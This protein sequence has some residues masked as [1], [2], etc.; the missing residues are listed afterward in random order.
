MASSGPSVGALLVDER[1]HCPLGDPLGDA[2]S[3]PVRKTHAA[4]RLGLGDLSRKGR[5]MYAVA[6]RRKVDPDVANRVIWSRLDRERLF[7]D[8]SA[9][10]VGKPCARIEVI[11]ALISDRR[12]IR[13]TSIPNNS[14]TRSTAVILRIVREIRRRGL[15]TVLGEIS[16]IRV[17]QILQ[18]TV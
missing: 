10:S 16:F 18:E 13:Q 4:M 15:A 5:A 12:W 7:G 1:D 9:Q 14:S 17:R 6:L 8:N 2:F 3:I 11:R